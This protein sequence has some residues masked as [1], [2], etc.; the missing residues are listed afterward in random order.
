[1]TTRVSRATLPA[2]PP[3]ARPALPSALP[4]PASA[5][6]AA[7]WGSPF[8][9]AGSPAGKC[10][11]SPPPLPA[12]SPTVAARLRSSSRLAFSEPNM[13]ACHR[14][15]NLS[16]FRGIT[17]AADF[18]PPPPGFAPSDSVAGQGANVSA[19]AVSASGQAS[20]ANASATAK[21]NA[22]L[23]SRL[24]RTGGTTERGRETQA[25]HRGSPSS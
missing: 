20:P 24:A 18:T 5:P 4:P 12:A 23:F 14:D 1:M 2:T 22:E 21:D 9:A 15:G 6:P 7:G 3:W 13:S 10:A 19:P 25:R 17:E 11:C 8:D 16:P